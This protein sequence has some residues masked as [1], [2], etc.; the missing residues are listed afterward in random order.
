M[1]QSLKSIDHLAVH[2]II[3]LEQLLAFLLQKQQEEA[4][5]IQNVSIKE[6]QASPACTLARCFLALNHPNSWVAKC[7]SFSNQLSTQKKKEGWAKKDRQQCGRKCPSHN[8]SGELL[9][10]LDENLSE[11]LLGYRKP[12]KKYSWEPQFPYFWPHLMDSQGK[13]ENAELTENHRVIRGGS[14]PHCGA[15]MRD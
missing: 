4:T 7:S 2:V 14:W 10:E 6:V 3:A 9:M 15:T 1:H 13:R 11:C 5:Y 8:K 12:S